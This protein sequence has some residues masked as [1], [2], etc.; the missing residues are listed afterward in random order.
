MVARNFLAG[1][2]FWSTSPESVHEVRKKTVLSPHRLR[3]F[4]AR[5]A[6]FF[7]NV[8]R[9][10]LVLDFKAFA[11]YQGRSTFRK[12][13]RKVKSPIERFS[14]H[15]ID[16]ES[17]STVKRPSFVS[18]N[19]SQMAQNVYVY[20]FTRTSNVCVNYC[21]WLIFFYCTKFCVQW[22]TLFT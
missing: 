16:R 19:K 1:S 3:I 7:Q 22:Q 12:E 6:I 11:F 8:I 10:S 13:W 20:L 17:F 18:G 2:M 4:W 5:S 9:T 15:N 21:S 14:T